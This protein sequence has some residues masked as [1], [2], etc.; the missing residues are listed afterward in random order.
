MS[1]FWFFTLF[2]AFL[3][4]HARV[5]LLAVFFVAILLTSVFIF[6]IVG[7]S[8]F[9]IGSS[10][11]RKFSLCGAIQNIRLSRARSFEAPLKY[12]TA[13][14]DLL[15][16]RFSNTSGYQRFCL[17][18]EKFRVSA[19]FFDRRAPSKTIARRLDRIC[20]RERLPRFYTVTAF[21]GAPPQKPT[22]KF[23][24]AN[25]DLLNRRFSDTSGYLKISAFYGKFCMRT[26]VVLLLYILISR[27]DTHA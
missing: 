6:T 16:R 17:P 1:F 10:T 14:L 13:N 7:V 4:L 2:A 26:S 11:Y 25:L 12:F 23:F 9:A 5:E 24:R 27:F 22:D 21:F 19:L 20:R 18:L 8:I 3:E 15:N